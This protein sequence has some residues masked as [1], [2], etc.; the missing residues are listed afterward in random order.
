MT[1]HAR[2]TGAERPESLVY[3]V[4]DRP[5]LAVT[6]LSGLQQA[7]VAIAISVAVLSVVLDAAQVDLAARSNALQVALL[8]LG[9]A[10]VLQCLR[11]G[12]IG[13]GYLVPAV[14]ATSYLPGAILAA[15]QG[16]MP[17]VAGMTIFAGVLTCA[18]AYA[19][20]RM[21]PYFPTEVAG[22]V[23]FT[24]G[25]GMGDIGIRA[26]L[27]PPPGATGGID[28]SAALLAIGLVSFMVG[29][30]VWSSGLVRVC[31]AVLGIGLGY[32][33]AVAIGMLPPDEL[34]R[35]AR[36]PLLDAPAPPS[37]SPMFAA[38]LVLPF[39]IGALACCLR[40]IGDVTTAQRLN[41]T[42]WVRPDLA[43]IEGGL[44]ASGIGNVFAGLLGTSGANTASS[45]VGLSG[46]TGITARVAG[47]AAGGVLVALAFLPAV[48]TTFAIMP[49]TIVG[50]VLLFT[51]CMVMVNGIQIIASRLLD[52]RKTF[53]IG[54]PT[55]LGLTLA[56]APGL[57]A[58]VPVWLKPFFQS[59][60]VLSILTALALNAVF[61]IGVRKAATLA[62][63]LAQD[64]AAH[65]I[66]FVQRQGG[67]WGARQDVMQR[68]E[69]AVG[70]MAE[71]A[72]AV[73]TPGGQMSVTA[74]FDEFRI[75]VVVSYPGPPF[76]PGDRPQTAEELILSCDEG[77]VL[78]ASLLVTRSADRIQARHE[79]GINR[80]RLEFDQ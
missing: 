51:G 2:S 37:E 45:G 17:L 25:I 27:V 58:E 13:S 23:V 57:F 48:A 40:G 11:V 24:I 59:P 56:S 19:V 8:V 67:A 66:H 61:R 26:I 72:L 80:V 42:R 77:P 15:E 68:V 60:V 50:A 43:S 41:D 32:V 64:A 75:D 12:L 20:P 74:S 54:L 18:L 53:V 46:V 22:F 38:D 39:A 35:I 31:S 73:A 62:I 49:R 71:I 6:L 33:A 1:K 55:I 29:L 21:R 78:L 65:A 5:P 52:I 70:E 4:D 3:A 47:F 44:L 14:F 63:D 30:S 34:A 10:T 79:G 69:R 7:V 36:A 28:G 9:L 16:G 76:V